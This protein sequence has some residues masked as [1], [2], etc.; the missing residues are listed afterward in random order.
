[1]KR[2]II[3]GVFASIL[4]LNL[5]ITS[6]SM[7]TPE[8][9]L[10][11]IIGKH[12]A[13]TAIDKYPN[14]I[15]NIYLESS[16]F[17]MEL[18]PIYKK[19]LNFSEKQNS[20]YNKIENEINK[21]NFLTALIGINELILSHLKMIAKEIDEEKF[22][23]KIKDLFNKLAINFNKMEIPFSIK[24]FKLEQSAEIDLETIPFYNKSIIKIIIN[25]KGFIKEF[26]YVENTERNIINRKCHL[27]LENDREINFDT[28]YLPFIIQSFINEIKSFIE[29]NR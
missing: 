2:F 13:Q 20:N 18:F 23:V 11:T 6:Y 5:N 21:M 12:L 15:K 22:K 17:I 28:S 16:K 4:A 8:T 3:T 19:L 10:G 27:K 29:N 14:E 24:N 1:M 25:L 26:S 7:S 9:N